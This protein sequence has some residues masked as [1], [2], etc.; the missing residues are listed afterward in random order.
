MVPVLIAIVLLNFISQDHLLLDAYGRTIG[1]D[2]LLACNHCHETFY[3]NCAQAIDLDTI[4]CSYKEIYCISQSYY[5]PWNRG[6][7]GKYNFHRGCSPCEDIECAENYTMS[8][9]LLLREFIGETV[10]CGKYFNC[11]KDELSNFELED[12]VGIK[13]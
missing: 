11:N 4:A 13:S 5:D 2:I 10:V 6:Y 1:R 3:G 7:G 8:T 12:V 9:N